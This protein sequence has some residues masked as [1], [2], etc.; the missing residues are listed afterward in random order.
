MELSENVTKTVFDSF[1]KQFYLH[2]CVRYLN[3]YELMVKIL[4][5]F[6]FKY[7]PPPK[8]KIF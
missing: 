8:K 4:I 1:L 2:W 3:D 7:S 5:N 6:R